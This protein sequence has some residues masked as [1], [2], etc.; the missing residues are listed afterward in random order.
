MNIKVVES[1]KRLYETGVKNKDDFS[2]RV[3]KG[4]LTESEYFTITN[5]KYVK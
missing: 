4:T 5:E 1:M 2:M 3:I